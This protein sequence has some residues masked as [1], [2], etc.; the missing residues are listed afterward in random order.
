MQAATLSAVGMSV[1]GEI[2]ANTGRAPSQAI[3]VDVA[4]YVNGV[5]ITSPPRTSQARRAN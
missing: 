4:T 3:A 1:S 5:V 2:S